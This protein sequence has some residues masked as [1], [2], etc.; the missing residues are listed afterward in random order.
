MTPPASPM[1][2][3]VSRVLT[4]H[5]ITGSPAGLHP[6][7]PPP[8]PPLVSPQAR[9][10]PPGRCLHAG[11]EG[12]EKV[13]RPFPTPCPQAPVARRASAS[14]RPT[15]RAPREGTPVCFLDL[16][17]KVLSTLPTEYQVERDP[18]LCPFFCA[19]QPDFDHSACTLRMSHP[20]PLGPA[21]HKHIPIGGKPLQIT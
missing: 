1:G 20:E 18:R 12:N 9:P 19:C 8:T 5:H 6:R 16:A 11:D 7:G 13:R 10:R 15:Q 3:W 4:S 21:D 14:F 17:S 2:S